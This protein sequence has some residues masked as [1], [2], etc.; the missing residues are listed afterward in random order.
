MTD[1][2][3]DNDPDA[4]VLRSELLDFASRLDGMS[5]RAM[6]DAIVEIAWKHDLKREIVGARA[7]AEEV[8]GDCGRQ[9]VGRVKK[10]EERGLC[11]FRRWNEGK[12]ISL[13]LGEAM[14]LRRELQARGRA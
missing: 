14:V 3:N 6:L 4:V 10:F 5:Y 7:I 2:D 13:L 12:T 11:T 1:A 8:Y 9:A